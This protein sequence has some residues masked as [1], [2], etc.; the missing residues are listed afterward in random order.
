[1]SVIE[2]EDISRDRSPGAYHR[3]GLSTRKLRNIVDDL[4]VL[5]ASLKGKQPDFSAGHGVAL[6]GSADGAAVE[7]NRVIACIRAAGDKVEAYFGEEVEPGSIDAAHGIGREIVVLDR[8]GIRV[9]QDDVIISPRY[10]EP[11]NGAEI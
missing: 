6:D 4:E 5:G 7:A 2:I 1:M 9:E 8:N 3:D 10:R 11:A